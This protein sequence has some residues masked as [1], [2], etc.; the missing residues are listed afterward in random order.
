MCETSRLGPGYTLWSER[1]YWSHGTFILVISW[2]FISHSRVSSLVGW[3]LSAHQRLPVKSAR[4]YGKKTKKQKKKKNLVHSPPPGLDERFS[5]IDMKAPSWFWK[6][7]MTAGLLVFCCWSVVL[8]V[9]RR[10]LMWGFTVSPQGCR[11][12]RCAVFFL[13]LSL[14]VCVNTNTKKKTPKSF[15]H[16]LGL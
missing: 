14:Y 6:I 15:G 10:V 2:F 16:S 1:G 11:R 9:V 13:F 7:S 12:Y 4:K 8:S 5:W 3:K